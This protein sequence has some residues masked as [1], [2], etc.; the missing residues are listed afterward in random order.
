MVSPPSTP[1]RRPL[2]ERSG[3]DTNRSSVRLVPQ[4]PPRL[5]TGRE[6]IYSRTP[7]PTLA[8]HV[9]S[10]VHSR[11]ERQGSALDE[12]QDDVSGRQP[13]LKSPPST[14][15]LRPYSSQTVRSPAGESSSKPR[16]APKKLKHVTVR[17][18]KTFSVLD[19]LSSEKSRQ[20]TENS[21][22]PAVAES[23]KD[24]HALKSPLRS[25]VPRISQ[26]FEAAPTSPQPASRS[27]SRVN[28]LVDSP[29]NY[30]IFGG[31]RQ[32]PKT[33]EQKKYLDP[34][35]FSSADNTEAFP[36]TTDESRTSRSLTAQSSFLSDTSTASENTNY[37]VYESATPSVSG[38]VVH[39]SPNASSGSRSVATKPSFISG[40]STA[41]ENANYRTY[42]ENTP[43]RA[44]PT[45]DSSSPETATPEPDDPA[46]DVTPVSSANETPSR[47]PIEESS[48]APSIADSG[49]FRVFGS[50]SPAVSPQPSLPASADGSSGTQGENTDLPSTSYVAIRAPRPSNIPGKYSQESLVPPVLSKKSNDKLGYYKSRSRE[51]L[52]SPALNP[53][54]T[55]VNQQASRAVVQRPSLVNLPNPKKFTIP[56]SWADQA[57]SLPRPVMQ[58][59]PHQWSSQLSTVLSESDAPSHR[60]SHEWADSRNSRDSRRSRGS[61][62]GRSSSRPALSI[63]S[64]LQEQDEDPL[65]SLEPP[66]L[67][68][69]RQ[70]DGTVSTIRMVEDDDEYQ[71]QVSEMPDL[72]SHTSRSRLSSSFSSQFSGMSIDSRSRTN[73]LRSRTN[74]LRSIASSRANS[75]H[76]HSILASSLPTWAK[77]YYGSGERKYL[78]APGS[79]T[80]GTDSRPASSYRSGSPNTDHFPLSIYSPRRRPRHVNGTDQRASTGSLDIA[81]SPAVGDHGVARY[82]RIKKQTSSLWSP[83]LR[84]DRRAVSQSIWVAPDMEYGREGKLGRRNTQI[85]LFIVG[86]IFPFAWMI[87]SFLPLPPNPRSA[88]TQSDSDLDVESDAAT[89]KFKPAEEAT[90]ESAKWWRTLNRY[91]SLLGLLIIGAVVSSSTA[92]Q[93]VDIQLMCSRSRSSSSAFDRVGLDSSMHA[94]YA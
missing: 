94:P 70:R 45:H 81:P 62:T 32:V 52:R 19:I 7:L 42:G 85:I 16:P 84:I 50:S 27:S 3:S 26:L 54:S 59:S 17:P 6:D 93:L 88:Q 60:G 24:T 31:L 9:L 55:V 66:Q 58:A 74:S 29:Y 78:A 83:H 22:K 92:L 13:S 36:E 28:S 43:P 12:S 77:V 82:Y 89:P 47:S 53:P 30:E 37:K 65:E 2:H 46:F 44:V 80:E 61:R 68:H 18:D 69:L 56:G 39:Y 76:A 86:F 67:A 91:M 49:N 71:D 40:S 87:A 64:S 25:P 57:L 4:S 14:P 41:S 63:G 11:V 90:F 51:T 1:S 33:P 34:D 21:Q 79:S 35:Y 75:L 38:T 23:S 73:S 5:Y 15:S 72:R 20:A 8:S 48:S 10:P